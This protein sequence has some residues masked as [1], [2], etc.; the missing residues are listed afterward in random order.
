VPLTSWRWSSLSRAMRGPLPA[1][2]TTAFSRDRLEARPETAPWRLGDSR[3]W[4]AVQFSRSAWSAGPGVSRAR[5][6]KE[7]RPQVSPRVVSQNST[8]CSRA[9]AI[10]VPCRSDQVRSTF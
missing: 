7:A 5:A 1:S 9:P 2:A 6:P 10:P 8:A 3:C 4:L